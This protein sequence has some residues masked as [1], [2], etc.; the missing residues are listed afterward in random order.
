[1]TLSWFSGCVARLTSHAACPQP[2]R[3]SSLASTA[4]E[5]EQYLAFSSRRSWGTSHLQDAWAHFTF[6]LIT[7]CFAIVWVIRKVNQRRPADALRTPGPYQ[8]ESIGGLTGSIFATTS[9]LDG[10]CRY[11]HV[12][13]KMRCAQWG[14]CGAAFLLFVTAASKA[15][16][17]ASPAEVPSARPP[18][19][20]AAG[21][22]PDV[23]LLK[24]GG[25]LRGT[26]GELIPG[27][28]V[29]IRTV[30]GATKTLA[31]SDVS[32]AGPKER[33]PTPVSASPT[34]GQGQAPLAAPA[35]G[36][37]RV[38]VDAPLVPFRF[39]SGQPLTLHLRGPA[40]YNPVCTAP[41][42][43]TLQR[44][45]YALALSID[46]QR[47]VAVKE[48]TLIQGRSRIDGTYVS[49][50]R[51]RAAGWTF[52]G[53]G[54]AVST[55]GFVYAA[56]QQGSTCTTTTGT[57][58]SFGYSTSCENRDPSPGYAAGVIGLVVAGVGLVMGL[59][60]DEAKVFVTPE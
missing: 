25:L 60:F 10:A 26:I 16:G 54:L 52:L 18:D 9:R 14:R 11:G 1:M 34:T 6:R 40:G 45:S 43:G 19:D 22:A 28:S 13:G 51:A 23:V 38:T 17:Q 5:S 29:T 48:L 58:G 37:G 59:R 44:G 21:A 4:H 27:E 33:A 35:S 24:N 3:P 53:L 42:A 39:L 55:I 20:A 46:A 56:T 57:S 2:H 36:D 15:S 30:T 31:M 49:Y 32:Y 41:C 50:K 7:N 8:S 47:P 12:V